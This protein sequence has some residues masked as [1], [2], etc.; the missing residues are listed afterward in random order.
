M[1]WLRVLRENAV[2]YI[3]LFLLGDWV[4]KACYNYHKVLVGWPSG[5]RTHLMHPA[6][7]LMYNIVVMVGAC[8]RED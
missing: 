5:D 7:P 4:L 2:N 3:W 1:C 6:A 8:E